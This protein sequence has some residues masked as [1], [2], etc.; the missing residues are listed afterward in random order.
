MLYT[1]YLKWG[2]LSALFLTLFVPFL[3]ADGNF[4]PAFF[5]PFITGKNFAFRL[6]VEIALG[7]YVLLALREP[8]YRPR[9]SIIGWTALA[10]VVW[11]GIANIL[12]VE[13]VKSFWSNFERMEGY[14]G[15]LHMYAYFLV[16]GA[17]LSA[18]N[19]WYRFF[20]TSIVASAI[21]GFYA[22]LQIF[23]A[24]AISTQSGVRVDTT[25]GN[26]TYL[27]VYLLIHL[28]LTIYMLSRYY[29]KGEKGVG[30]PM[31]YGA[32]L[33]LQGVALYYTETRGA[34]LGAVG[35]LLV[36]ALYLALF[37][38]AREWRVA[39]T[40]ALW[41]IGAIVLLGAG[42]FAVK[43]TQ[44]IRE[45]PAL[46]RLASISLEDNTT[47]ARFLV[48]GMALEGFKERPVT[49]W[50]QENFSYVFNANYKPEMYGQEAWFD[51]AHNQFLDWLISGG[52]P[53]FVLYVGLYALL[54]FVFFR[55]ESLSVAEKAALIGLLAG[56]TFNNLFVF[57]NLVSAM[58]FFALLA[59]GHSLSKNQL[60]AWLPLTKPAGD[61][62]V[63]IAA[64]VVAVAFLV[65]GWALNMPSMVRA[66]NIIPAVQTAEETV[67]AQGISTRG[68]K[69]PQKNLAQ[70]KE[71]FAGGV[72]PG[73]G[74]GRQE[75]AEQLLQYATNSIAPSAVGPELKEQIFSYAYE[76]AKIM[77]AERKNDARLELFMA[78]FL[79]QVG[80]YDEAVSYLNAALVHS[81]NKQQILFQLGVTYVQ[82]GDNASA[83][84]AFKKAFDLAPE[85]DTARILYAAGYYY[86]NQQAAGDALLTERFGSVIVD[87]GT[88]LQIYTNTKQYQRTVDIWKLRIA[89]DSKNLDLRMS[90]A[91]AYFT[92]GR[93]EET[94]QT[95]RDIAAL[96]PNRALEMQ[97]IITQIQNGTLKP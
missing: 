13:P 1:T 24:I 94:I 68:A 59:F 6:L 40:R 88:L 25:F 85:N 31:L 78:T 44:F 4:V 33:A 90:L 14:V 97:N 2:V 29:G 56:Y 81:P 15:L 66:A 79:S 55:S 48:W 82:A 47:K 71:S 80:R 49:G 51:R 58:Y 64:P 3:V 20:N 91:S 54:A 52:L 38:R 50:G 36:M 9:S 27:A 16:A 11:M 12:S 46:G 93:L 95:L 76:S 92:A 57:D 65:G 41:A 73:S 83:L 28:F 70:F 96:D 32:A 74:V 17:V 19:L 18:E 42:F 69:D 89:A 10:F 45:S 7:L 77:L 37:A 22:L 84:A 62:A 86:S 30:I 53:A 39:R 23:G 72:W 34:I 43:D 60:P 8:K 63:A 26:A 61:H 75:V 21:M 87:N 67:N 5:F 35:G